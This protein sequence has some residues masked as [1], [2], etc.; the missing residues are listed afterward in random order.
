MVTSRKKA[1]IPARDDKAGIN[2]EMERWVDGHV[3]HLARTSISLSPAD[4][5]LR[6]LVYDL[7]FLFDRKYLDDAIDAF[8]LLERY[9]V[10]CVTS[11][12]H[13]TRTKYIQKLA[14]LDAVERR[15]P[16]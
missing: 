7:D 11:T 1:D 15:L 10:A 8:D 4:E 5:D 12:I 3:T 9:D 14:F 2:A 13:I 16:S 6:D